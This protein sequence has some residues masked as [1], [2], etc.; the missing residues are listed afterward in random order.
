MVDQEPTG[1]KATQG[2]PVTAQ[3]S[4]NEIADE[5]REMGTN[6][7]NFL[8]ALWESQESKRM[9]KDIEAGLA[10][11]GTSINQA[12]KEFQESPTGQRVKEEFEEISERIRT[13]EIETNIRR[14][15]MA[16]LKTANAE[17]EK[18]LNKMSSS[19]KDRTGSEPDSKN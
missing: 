18:A 7:M 3:A 13:G 10:N 1:E 9:Q 11:L 12:A 2:E 16:A 14:D 8:Q 6:I 19:G 5:L 17:L 15:F 4:Q